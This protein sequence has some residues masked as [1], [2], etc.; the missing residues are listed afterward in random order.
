MDLVHSGHV[1]LGHQVADFSPIGV[2][3]DPTLAT[4]EKGKRFMDAITQAVGTFLKDFSTWELDT[5]CTYQE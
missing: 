3:G 4:P 5:L 1:S 2:F